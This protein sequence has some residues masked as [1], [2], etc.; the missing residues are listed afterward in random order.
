MKGML[1]ILGLEKWVLGEQRST[2]GKCCQEFENAANGNPH[3][4]D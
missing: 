3:L 1:Q 2:A 4:A